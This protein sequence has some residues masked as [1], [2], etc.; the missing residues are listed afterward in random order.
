MAS[1]K[2]TA[3]RHPPW[4]VG[5]YETKFKV[6]N[7]RGFIEWTYELTIPVDGEVRFSA[8]V[9][10]LWL[11]EDSGKPDT[12]STTDIFKGEV[13]PSGQINLRPDYRSIYESSP[14]VNKSGYSEVDVVITG[15][16]LVRVRD[17]V[18]AYL[19]VDGKQIVLEQL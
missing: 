9:F 11:Q 8:N 1:Q 4:M 10:D 12:I 13:T 17:R 18:S 16:K 6:K 3:E 19:T 5:L 2:Q 7:S 14:V 15:G